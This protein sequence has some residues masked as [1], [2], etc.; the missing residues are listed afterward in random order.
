MKY[1]TI[2]DLHFG[3]KNNSQQHNEDLQKFF[4]HIV[5]YAKSNDISNVIITGDTFQQR[6]KLDILTITSAMKSFKYL[7]SHLNIKAVKWIEQ[8]LDIAL[9]RMP[10]PL[11]KTEENI[12]ASHAMT[13]GKQKSEKESISTH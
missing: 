10:V 4:E 1:I 5:D 9:E 3:A 6:D 2:T 13:E 7:S 11:L 8:V 12:P